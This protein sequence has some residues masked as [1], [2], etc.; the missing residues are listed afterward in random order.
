[1]KETNMILENLLQ[2]LTEII[3]QTRTDAVACPEDHLPVNLA[4]DYLSEDLADHLCATP[5]TNMQF[6]RKEFL[7]A[8]GFTS[9]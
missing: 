4:L 5:P 9:W 2:K 6:N 8:C 3:A 7:L 1:M